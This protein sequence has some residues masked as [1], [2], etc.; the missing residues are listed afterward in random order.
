MNTETRLR[1]SLVMSLLSLTILLFF[2]FQQQGELKEYRLGD[3]FIQGGDIQ[4]GM[5]IDSLQN[6]CD[7]LYDELF[8]RHVENGRYESTFEHL[9]EVNPKL[10][11]EMEEWMNHETE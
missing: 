3:N 10:G 5:I 4:K 7:S 9:K 1:A 8:I 6:R 2:Y 11:E